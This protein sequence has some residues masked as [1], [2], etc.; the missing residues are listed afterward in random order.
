LAA[1][2]Y[3][4]GRRKAALGTPVRKFANTLC[5]RFKGDEEADLKQTNQ[6]DLP[7]QMTFKR[8]WGMIILPNKHAIRR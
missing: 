5:D 8:H 6:C 2:H 3:R 7:D 4:L 1:N